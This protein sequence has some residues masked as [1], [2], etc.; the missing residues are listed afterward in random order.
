MLLDVTEQYQLQQ[1]LSEMRQHMENL[2]NFSPVVLYQSLDDLQKGFMYVSPNVADILGCT[3]Q[4]MLSDPM[5][6]LNQ[7]HPE[8]QSSL[9]QHWEEDYKEYRFWSQTQQA[10][11]WLKDI[12]RTGHDDINSKYGGITNISAQKSAE[13]EQSRLARALEW[14]QKHLSET[15]QAMTDGVVTINAQGEIL[16]FK[17]CGLSVVWLYTRGFSRGQ[18]CT[19]AAPV[20]CQPTSG[21]YQPLFA[22]RREKSHWQRPSVARAA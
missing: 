16:S 20:T 2:L 5:F 22:N 4:Q 19:V 18:C 1:S 13:L 17:H 6:F 11:I 14:Q 12:R 3:V 10:Y 21:L 7:V 15:L 9:L 8:D